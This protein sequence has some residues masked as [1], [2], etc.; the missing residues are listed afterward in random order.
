MDIRVLQ[1]MLVHQ[2]RQRATAVPPRAHVGHDHAAARRHFLLSHH[3]RGGYDPNG[4]PNQLYAFP[5]PQHQ[6]YVQGPHDARSSPPKDS[7]ISDGSEGIRATN[8]TCKKSRCLKL[9]CQCFGNSTTCGNKC[10]CQSCHNTMQHAEHIEVAKNAILDRN[11]NAFDSKFCGVPVPHFFGNG[12]VKQPTN[13]H[14]ARVA[15][16]SKSIQQTFSTPQR[17]NKL[18]CKCR[19]SFCLKKYCECF[20]N[21][22]NCGSHCGCLNCKN[23]SPQAEAPRRIALVEAIIPKETRVGSKESVPLDKDVSASEKLSAHSKSEDRMTMIAAVAMTELFGKAPRQASGG[24]SKGAGA[25]EKRKFHN[26]AKSSQS[27]KGALR[28]SLGINHMK[29]RSPS[30]VCAFIP[31]SRRYNM[32]NGGEHGPSRHSYFPI[33][34]SPALFQY[35]HR[36]PRPSPTYKNVIKSIGLPKALSFR[37][38]CSRCGRARGEHSE[39]GFGNKCVFDDCGKCHAG[40]QIHKQYGSPMGVLCCL[41]VKEGAIPEQVCRYARKIRDLSARAMLLKSLKQDKQEVN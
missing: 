16:T 32:S 31:Q 2:P 4:Y 40:I 22:M 18:G 20:Q 12:I 21:Q 1:V 28:A 8:C 35:H 29:L 36:P 41:S 30:S 27:K 26:K 37:K 6:D 39:L 19:R 13:W 14:S 15:C 5:E 10:R 38:I 7:S 25:S 11:P 17:F 24:T 23:H 34:T 3:P 9:Y 33:Q